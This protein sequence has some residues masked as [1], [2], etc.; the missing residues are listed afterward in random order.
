MTSFAES[1]MDFTIGGNR[2][3]FDE[4]YDYATDVFLPGIVS[5]LAQL[6][7]HAVRDGL[8][9]AV[10]EFGDR[11][12]GSLGIIG[13]FHDL[14][15]N[16][17]FLGRS[18]VSASLESY[19]PKDQFTRS[20]SKAA[21]WIGR[22]LNYSPQKI[23]YLGNQVLGYWWKIQKALFPVGEE[24][25]DRS[26]GVKNTYFKDNVY[27]QDLVNWIYDEADK[28]ARKYKSS[29]DTEDGLKAKNDENMKKFYGNFYK[30]SKDET[31]SKA[32][33]RSRQL[34]LDMVNDYRSFTDTG[35][36]TP[37]Q[38]ALYGLVKETG[39]TSLLPATM[40]TYV[41]DGQNK[42]ELKA[43]GYIDYQTRYNELYWQYIEDNLDLNADTKAQTDA[44][45]AAKKI[46]AESAATY[47]LGQMGIVPEKK[48][49]SAEWVDQ[50][51]DLADLTA[52]N[53]AKEAGNQ[54]GAA[55]YLNSSGLSAAEKHALWELAGYSE[56]N[57]KKKVK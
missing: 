42:Y 2:H 7:V 18:I 10:T 54:D 8:D 38:E 11:T 22:G 41:N 47:A 3:S 35:I 40:Q 49:K 56:S 24:Y 48:S 46:A 45:K 21:Y 55:E 53:A 52:F 50:G 19:E 44:V 31:D 51:Y 15:A 27:S 20:T 37:V 33:R 12:I 30:L 5:D 32:V 28:S 25:I 43:A 34:V 16:R 36:M 17:D 4:Y 9:P 57:Y 23:D 1:V 13:A 26:L 29:Q 14:S 6:P 39:D